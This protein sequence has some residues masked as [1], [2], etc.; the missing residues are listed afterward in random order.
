MNTNSIAHT[1]NRVQETIDFA[2]NELMEVKIVRE[3]DPTDYALAQKQLDDLT[4]E[5]ETL[6]EDSPIEER[7]S[8][9]EAQEKIREVQETM[10]RGI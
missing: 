7:A 6:I 9:I 5:L 10:V 4:I 2:L 3:N 8:L 1:L